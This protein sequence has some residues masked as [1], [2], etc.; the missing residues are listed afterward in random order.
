LKTISGG[1][2]RKFEVMVLVR[3][4]GNGDFVAWHAAKTVR[5]V[6][7]QVRQVELVV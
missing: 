3:V 7:L 6:F 1:V 5:N 4:F 2:F